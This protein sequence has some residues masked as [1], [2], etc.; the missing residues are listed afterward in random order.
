MLPINLRVSY[1]N[2]NLRAQHCNMLV[3]HSFELILENGI[4]ESSKEFDRIIGA[5]GKNR[6]FLLDLFKQFSQGGVIPLSEEVLCRL[7]QVIRGEMDRM[8]RS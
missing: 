7:I 4:W 5:I 3:W 8:L 6:K 2:H 1:V